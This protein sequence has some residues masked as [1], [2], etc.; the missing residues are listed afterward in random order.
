MD[1]HRK[2]S[3]L[4]SLLSMCG[5]EVASID[6][7]PEGP[8]APGPIGDLG[9]PDDG[10]ID[11]EITANRP[12][13]LSVVGLARETAT[14]CRLPLRLPWDAQGR[15]INAARPGVAPT[16]A[17]VATDGL[18]VTI[19]DADLCPRY[20][21]AVAEVR[22][23]PSPPWLANRL[24]A[25]GVRP[26]ANI[27]DVTN[28]V[29]LEMGHPMHAF[30]LERL[31][32]RELRARRARLGERIR[33]LDGEARTLDPDMLVIADAGQ[34]QAIAGVMGGGLS[35]VGSDTR[36]VAFESAY[37]KPASVRRT[38]RRL[39]LK[40]EASARFERG[41]DINA[42]VVALERA[43]ALI[44]QIGAGRRVGPYLD[45]YPSP[46]G[47]I[48]IG[49][50]RER[51][52]R[53][54]GLAV[55]D[56]D[57]V[58]ILEGLGAS[59]APAEGGWRVEVPTMRVDLARE[60]DLIEELA[61]HH[62]YDRVPA[63]FPPLRAA[64]PRPDARIGRKNLLRHALTAAGFSEAISYSFLEAA[65][66]EVFAARP[67]LVALAYPLSETFAVLRPSLLPGLVGAVARNLRHEQADIRL[68]EI[69]SCFSA[70]GGEEQR[71]AFVWAGA[72]TPEHWSGGHR[73]V[74]FFDAKGV[75]ERIGEVLHLPLRFTDAAQVYLVP[76]RAAC[77]R[78]GDVV[79]GHLGQA[80]PSLARH[81]DVPGAEE[82]YLAE[83]S[84]E[85]IDAVVATGDRQVEALPR[86]PS[87]RPGHLNRHRRGLAFRARS[88]DHSRGRPRDARAS[89]RVRPLQGQGYPRRTLQPVP[90]AHVPL[91]R[92]DADRR[93]SAAG[94]GSDSHGAGPDAPRRPAV[95]AMVAAP[96]AAVGSFTPV[97]GRGDSV[98]KTMTP[99][100]LEALDRLEQ[101]V[102]LLAAELGR[103]RAEHAR[104]AEETGRLVA[105]LE[106]TRTR[107]AEAERAVSEMAGLRE[108]RD[109]VR[110]RVADILEQLEQLD[111]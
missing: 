73:P 16:A 78:A 97:P 90:S 35:E 62:G 108:E 12:D 21:A 66:A 55:G 104:Q 49:L 9:S 32:G 85:A 60:A 92:P 91:R 56:D 33:T 7:V 38:S 88:R 25:A 86:F 3:D 28:Y 2:V 103:L 93:R 23:G 58:R 65:A 102:K 20:A 19:E 14:A 71:L 57:V 52:A 31:G 99:S 22:V 18:T 95:A 5:F 68:F 43:C 10:V 8:L 61:R 101:K 17:H 77:V 107:L 80:A 45:C 94:D 15:P 40:T 81:H 98:T 54:L 41:T 100:D 53:L 30:D 29:L 84:L 4:A 105:D 79:I 76:G 110:S 70:N 1:A 87:N 6:P 75:V 109:Q 69:G 13:C 111:I 51:I 46:R 24:L 34:A 42:A 74:D 27:V 67:A 50:R 64:A 47:P 82:I 44:E 96:A 59:V 63:T 26:I 37:F 83:L 89:A 48:Q 106:T 39:G 72:G 11:F 36:L